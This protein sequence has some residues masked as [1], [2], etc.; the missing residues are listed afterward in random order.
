ML[1]CTTVGQVNAF[2]CLFK[3]SA[4]KG[5]LE[6]FRLNVRF[7]D[8]SN[9]GPNPYSGSLEY[10]DQT[11]MGGMIKGLYNRSYVNL[12]SVEGVFTN[13]PT[14]DMRILTKEVV[15]TDAHGG[16]HLPGK[17]RLWT[18]LHDKRHQPCYADIN[19]I[20]R[21]CGQYHVN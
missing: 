12:E 14:L 20:V 11:L 21:T 13:L 5:L 6:L 8:E 3:G 9:P 10:D 7:M 17:A 16:L 1:D 19:C 2:P 4:A 18:V 15:C